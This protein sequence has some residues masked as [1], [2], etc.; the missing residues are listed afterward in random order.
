MG[1]VAFYEPHLTATTL[2]RSL[3]YDRHSGPNKISVSHLFHYLKDYFITAYPLI[4]P[5]KFVW[6]DGGETLCQSAWS[7]E[8]SIIR[9]INLLAKYH[10]ATYL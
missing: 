2:I 3:C 7:F 9:H 1:N 8:N 6:L 5:D 10:P 4:R